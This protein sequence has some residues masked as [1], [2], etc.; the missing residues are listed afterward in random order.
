MACRVATAAL[1]VIRDEKLAENA[2]L[3]GKKLREGLRSIDSEAIELVRGRGLLNAIVIKVGPRGRIWVFL[4]GAFVGKTRRVV[5]LSRGETGLE[6]QGQRPVHLPV[7][8]VAVEQ[9]SEGTI[10]SV[11]L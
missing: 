6:R 8:R 1:K 5:G 4:W 10:F 7:I 9:Y 3:M 2:K 11:L